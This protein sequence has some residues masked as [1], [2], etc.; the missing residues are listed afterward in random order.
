MRFSQISLDTF[1]EFQLEAGMILK[2][3]NP[4][5]PDVKD[6][7][8]VCATTG[9]IKVDCVPTYKDN[10]DDVD[11]C[12]ANMMELMQITS[13]LATLGFTALSL[14]PDVIRIALGAA[15]IHAESGK[16]IP[17]DALKDE[18]FTDVWWV[19]DRSDGGLVA[20]RLINA[21]STSGF[22]LTTT[23]DGKG[24][25]AVTLRGH[26]SIK[27]QDVVPMEFY[28]QEGEAA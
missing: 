6:E 10:G 18:D 26:V 8:I 21:L 1:K 16:I 19:G 15:D 3:F 9:G 12:P 11:N 2:T 25:V 17:R 4:E 24:N 7:D 20:V 23:K 13:W 27:A 22:S 28:V 5:S 14:T